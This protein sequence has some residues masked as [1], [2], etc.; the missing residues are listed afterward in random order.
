[1]VPAAVANKYDGSA[2]RGPGRPAKPEELRDLIL[3]V[4][5]DNPS[6]GYTRIRDVR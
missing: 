1:M 6:W 5:R 4:A 2:K 3:T